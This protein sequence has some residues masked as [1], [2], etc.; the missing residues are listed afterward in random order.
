MKGIRNTG[1]ERAMSAH[2]IDYEFQANIYSTPELAALFDENS[3][4]E[5]WLRFEA[6]LAQSQAEVGVIPEEAAVEIGRKAS[7]ASLDPA[8]IREGYATSR[9]SLIPVLNALRRACKE[10]HGDYVH[11]GATTQDVID[12]GEMLALREALSIA[13]RDL[14]AIKGHLIR[15]ARTYRDTP[16]IGRTHGQQALPITFGAKASIWLAEV[17]RH[18]E[19]ADSL[20]GRIFRG[21]L[22]GAVGSMAALGP[23]AT[24]VKRR[25]MEKLALKVGPDSWHTARDDIGELCAS[26]TMIAA[27]MAKIANE[28]VLLGRT[29]LGELREPVIGRSTAGS[30][31]MPHKRNPV[32]CQRVVALAS[33]V[34]GLLSV[35]MEAM[36]HENERDP[37]ALWSEWLA[38]PQMAIYTCASLSSMAA[39]LSNLE[40]FP[41]RMLANLHMQRDM[42]AS[43]WLLFRLAEKIG[44]TQAQET[45]RSLLAQTTSSKQPLT[46]LLRA[47]PELVS[48]ISD[49]DLSIVEMPERYTGHSGEIVDAVLA[50]IG[51][52]DSQ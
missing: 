29:E 49:K 24:E 27:T 33:H 35:V 19:R 42:V 38:V 25:T 40:V 14:E 51:E 1:A 9:N 34:R 32:L 21:Q 10:P 7:L 4:I 6:A 43:E 47:R 15:L 45:V 48:V 52:R 3:R 17:H 31:T 36:I 37:R 2:P 8:L 44:K 41:E 46:D 18:C 26:F 50:S 5:R 11:Y 20:Q 16:M 28:I 23:S 39:V 12:T 30:S 22:S 13:R